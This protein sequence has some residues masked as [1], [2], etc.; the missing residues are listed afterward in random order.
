VLFVLAL[1]SCPTEAKEI[2]RSHQY[3][4]ATDNRITTRGAQGELINGDHTSTSFKLES[5]SKNGGEV[6]GVY[7]YLPPGPFSLPQTVAYI[8][9]GA[10]GYR[11]FADV[12]KVV[13]L[14]PFPHSL[15][16]TSS[17]RTSS[18]GSE[19][20]RQTPSVIGRGGP[21]VGWPWR[22][23][24]QPIIGDPSSLLI[25]KII[26]GLERIPEPHNDGDK[27]TSEDEEN[28]AVVIG[29]GGGHPVP[30][31]EPSVAVSQPE[32]Q[33]LAAGNGTSLVD[34]ASVA[35]AFGPQ[36]SAVSKP[37][38][39]AA[40][41]LGGIAISKPSSTSIAGFGGI[42]ISGG[43]SIAVSGLPAEAAGDTGSLQLPYPPT[44]PPSSF[45]QHNGF[46]PQ[47]PHKVAPHQGVFDLPYKARTVHRGNTKENAPVKEEPVTEGESVTSLSQPSVTYVIYPMVINHFYGNQASTVRRPTRFPTVRR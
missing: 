27:L 7:S 2:R 9:G 24:G 3:H 38:S 4:V 25:N 33:A 10:N 12:G 47:Q 29:G 44:P 39:A 41:G 40:A 19:T 8:A 32:A 36:G 35:Q 21:F 31:D 5:R 22:L 14:P 28:N 42:A 6:R 43:Q 23:P 20:A 18:G 11:T 13:Q 15:Q 16:Q 37:Q 45:H 46:H 30:D 26:A 1:W 17:G 34:T